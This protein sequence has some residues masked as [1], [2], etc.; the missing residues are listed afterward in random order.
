MKRV[1]A[2][3]IA[4]CLLL[5]A[6]AGLAEQS[7]QAEDLRI[8]GDFAVSDLNGG[9]QTQAIFGNAPLTLVNFWGTFCP[10]CI[11]EMPDLAALSEEYAGRLQIVGVVGDAYIYPDGV[12]QEILDEAE[13][14]C[15]QTGAGVYTHLIPDE[16]MVIRVLS[17]LQV[18]PTTAFIDGQGELIGKVVFGSKAK[19]EW[20]EIIDDTL[21]LLPAEIPSENAPAPTPAA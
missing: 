10:P 14:I 11:Q 16:N 7:E 15:E 1:L 6:W 2:M 12:S 9:E 8:F 4:L 5:P 20:I 19:D 18:Y 21:A 3:A 13:A 17:A